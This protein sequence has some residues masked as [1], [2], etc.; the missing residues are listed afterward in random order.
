[1]YFG[2]I[3]YYK[4]DLKYYY[5]YFYVYFNKYY[6]LLKFFFFKNHNGNYLIYHLDGQKKKMKWQDFKGGCKYNRFY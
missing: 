2:Y 4:P 1:M 3:M 6:Y 5:Y